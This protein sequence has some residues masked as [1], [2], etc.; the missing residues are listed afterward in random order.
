MTGGG[1]SGGS[2]EHYQIVDALKRQP[3]TP[4]G[5]LLSEHLIDDIEI[6]RGWDPGSLSKGQLDIATDSFVIR[7][8]DIIE[9]QQEEPF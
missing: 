1:E 4:L 9:R 6:L 7:Q 8:R 5:K 2:P 3:R